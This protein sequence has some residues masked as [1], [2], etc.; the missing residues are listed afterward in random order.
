MPNHSKEPPASSRAPNRDLKDIDVLC[1]FKIKIESQNSDYWCDRARTDHIQIM[2]KILNP[3]QEHPVSFQAPNQD[4]KSRLRA[5]I[6]TIQNMD[7]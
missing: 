3:N 6:C 4:L 7:V 1:T 2:I 5:K